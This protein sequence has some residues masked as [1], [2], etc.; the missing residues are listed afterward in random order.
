MEK[1]IAQDCPHADPAAKAEMAH[2]AQVKAQSSKKGQK[3]KGDDCSMQQA[4]QQQV[5]QQHMEGLPPVMPLLEVAQQQAAANG[6]AWFPMQRQC[7]CKSTH[8]RLRHKTCLMPR[9]VTWTPP[10]VTELRL[11]LHAQ[12]LWCTAWQCP[13]SSPR[14][15]W[16]LGPQTPVQP[17]HLSRLLQVFVSSMA[18]MHWPPHIYRSAA[19]VMH[20]FLC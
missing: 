9:C 5:Q 17:L 6:D 19:W 8:P 14:L 15:C 13:W 16:P 3:R 10:H 11:C 18:C 2:I 7:V 1:H 12:A 4:Q 20:C